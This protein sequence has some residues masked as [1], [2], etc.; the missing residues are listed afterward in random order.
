PEEDEPSAPESEL[1][2]EENHLWTESD[3]S[4]VEKQLSAQD[5]QLSLTVEVGR[6]KINLDKLLQLKPGNILEL[7]IR[8]EQGVD[9][10]IGG[11][12]MAKAEL[13]KLGDVLGIK[14]LHLND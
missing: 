13:V 1:P 14:I 12:K 3:E 11:K 2:E 7:P 6:L 5:I 8:P 10:S 9:L 4:S